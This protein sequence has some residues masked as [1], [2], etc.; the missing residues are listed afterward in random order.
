MNSFRP[1]IVT[2]KKQTQIAA[3]EAEILGIAGGIVAA[4]GP[5]ALSMERVLTEVNFSKGTLYNHFSSRE[6]L[7]V[8]LNAKCFADHLEYFERGA[9]FHGRTRERF[10]ATGMGHEIKQRIDPQPVDFVLT[11]DILQHASERWRSAFID[12]HRKTL[13]VFSGIVRDAIAS[14]D[15]S[16]DWAPEF[17][18][19][20]VWSLSVGAMDLFAGGLIY[21]GTA[22]ET[23][24]GHRR[25]MIAT[26]LDGFAWLP[27]SKD[28]D[29]EAT[30]ARVLSEIYR[31]EAT[32]LGI[33]P[34]T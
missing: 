26:L 32:R 10:L 1:S 25:R 16:G 24:H 31:P 12:A 2:S 13:S 8:A 22:K 5:G 19:S 11:D 27:L 34:N 9:L 18:A 21:R 28:H 29:Y 6:D 17:V 7:L 20:A 15:L 4:N 33:L 23:F 14:G 3:R 30:R